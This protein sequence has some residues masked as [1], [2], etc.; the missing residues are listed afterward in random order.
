MSAIRLLIVFHGTMGNGYAFYGQ[1]NK[2][3]LIKK[4]TETI[5]YK[6]MKYNTKTE[7][8]KKMLSTRK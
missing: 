6:D 2:T 1:L 5:S 8:K 4:S 7:E 3:N